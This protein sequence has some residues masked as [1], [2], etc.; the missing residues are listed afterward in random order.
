MC[1]HNDDKL[2]AT[3][4]QVYCYALQLTKFQYDFFPLQ[5]ISQQVKSSVHNGSIEDFALLAPN[6]VS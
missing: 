6:A 5:R 4:G 3:A 1:G 2:L